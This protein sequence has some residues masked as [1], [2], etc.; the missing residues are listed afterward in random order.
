MSRNGVAAFG[1]VEDGLYSA[2]CQNGLGTAKGMTLGLAAAD[3][4]S[5]NRTWIVDHLLEQD[6][7]RRLPPDPITFLGANAVMPWGEWSAGREM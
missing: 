3:L 5:G 1:E 2:C 7:P 4:A 6:A